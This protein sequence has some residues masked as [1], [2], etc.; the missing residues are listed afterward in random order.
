MK[1]AALRS[2][3]IPALTVLFFL[4]L[5]GLTVFTVRH[6]TKQF[7]GEAMVN[8][9]YHLANI[10]ER[11]NKE[12]TILSFDY[13]KNNINF[14]NVGSFTGS[15]VGPMN[16]AYPEK[17]NGPYMEDN[18]T[19]QGKEYQIVRTDAGYFIV[20]GDGV[21]LPNGKVMGKD[22]ILTQETNVAALAQDPDYVSFN[23][24]PLALKLDISSKEISLPDLDE[25]PLPE[26]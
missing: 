11:I 7:S 20:P 4:T 19:M 8:D 1:Q 12:C 21:Q 2:Y 6:K 5:I 17:W 26:F 3:I 13:Q 22:I 14:L 24:K 18:P 16:L 23:S 15:E 10:F 9:I 25:A